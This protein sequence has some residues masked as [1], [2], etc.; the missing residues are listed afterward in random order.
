M[1]K[2]SSLLQEALS[3]VREIKAF[4]AE[5]IEIARFDTKLHRYFSTI[6]RCVHFESLGPALIELVAMAGISAVLYVAALQVLSG[7]MT[8]GQ[9]TSFFAAVFLAYQPLKKLILVY[10]YLQ[11][12]LGAAASQ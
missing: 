6:M 10:T 7:T 2:V 9:L 11:Y 5:K 8:P 1:S 4:N 3:G 12:G